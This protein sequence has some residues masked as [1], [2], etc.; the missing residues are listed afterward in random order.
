M[1]ERL[2]R[3][4]RD[5]PLKKDAEGKPLCRWDQKPVPAGRRAY[6]SEACQIEVDIRCSASSLRYHVGLRDKGVCANCGCD[7][8]RLRRILKI[9]ERAFYEIN[10]NVRL[11]YACWLRITD[12]LLSSTGFNFRSHF[13]EAD[14]IVEVING[15]DSGLANMQTLCVPCHKA[16]TKQMHADLKEARTGIKPRPPVREV[17]VSLLYGERTVVTRLAQI[18]ARLAQTEET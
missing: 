4:D 5:F 2:A 13:W 18:A 16:K 8:K 12:V 17:Q 9:A 11:E 10:I 15:G 7:T 3:R 1:I 6:C 14:H